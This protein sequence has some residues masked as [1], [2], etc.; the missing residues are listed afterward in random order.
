MIS[1]GHEENFVELLSVALNLSV[2]IVTA[3]VA[4]REGPSMAWMLTTLKIRSRYIKCRQQLFQAFLSGLDPLIGRSQL[5]F[6]SCI[7]GLILKLRL[8]ARAC[9][10]IGDARLVILTRELLN[11]P[12]VKSQIPIVRVSLQQPFDLSSNF[13]KMLRKT[14]VDDGESA[15]GPVK[16]IHVRPPRLLGVRECGADAMG[17]SHVEMPRLS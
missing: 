3:Q 2:T 16:S 6:L 9:L 17:P 13:F 15:L 12:K 14:V 10:V 1:E 7:N 5:F 4:E 8:D 11:L